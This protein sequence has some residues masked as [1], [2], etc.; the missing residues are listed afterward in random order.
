LER[1][2]QASLND[3]YQAS[4]DAVKDL[5]MQVVEKNRD[6]TPADI[7]STKGDTEYWIK[8]ESKGDQVTTVSV[9]AGLLGNKTA[10]A[11]IQNTIEKAL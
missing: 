3:T 4:L 10:S 11:K 8:M 2:H 1:D 5:D 9:C 6:L 7:K